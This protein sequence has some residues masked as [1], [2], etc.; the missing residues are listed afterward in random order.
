ME[1]GDLLHRVITD[2]AVCGGMACVRGTRIPIAIIL[3]TLA[4]GDSAE[5]ILDA[6]PNLTIDDIHAA[7]AYAGEL[8]RETVWRVAG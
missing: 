7:L 4:E 6:Y 1:R 5:S 2:P 8:A 3:D